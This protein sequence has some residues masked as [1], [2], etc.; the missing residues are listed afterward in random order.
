MFG[1]D[2]ELIQTII[3]L[4]VWC[5]LLSIYKMDKKENGTIPPCG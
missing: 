3:F 1:L 5:W 4:I 2:L